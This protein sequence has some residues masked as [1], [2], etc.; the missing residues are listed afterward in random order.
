MRGKEYRNLRYHYLHEL[1]QLR[2]RKRVHGQVIIK[3]TRAIQRL[4]VKLRKEY[5]LK[6][7]KSNAGTKLQDSKRT[8]NT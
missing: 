5:P 6:S 8:G 3:E 7:E 4:L 2:A 1:T